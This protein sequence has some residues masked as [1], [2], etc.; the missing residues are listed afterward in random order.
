MANYSLN[1]DPPEPDRTLLDRG[2]NGLS[3]TTPPTSYEVEALGP[4]PGQL[5]HPLTNDV[6]PSSNTS[7]KPL[8]QGVQEQLVR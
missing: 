5:T 6:N 4:P 1:N 2:F 7:V 8:G 3:E